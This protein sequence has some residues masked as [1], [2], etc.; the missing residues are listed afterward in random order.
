MVN[1]SD[2]SVIDYVNAFPSIAFCLE[3]RGGFSMCHRLTLIKE[4]EIRPLLFAF[5]F[6]TLYNQFSSFAQHSLWPYH[7]TNCHLMKVVAS[8]FLFP[9]YSLENSAK[10]KGIDEVKMTKIIILCLKESKL[11]CRD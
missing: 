10:I 5:D 4:F 9:T 3:A 8:Y 11:T 6:C 1:E 7:I 2:A